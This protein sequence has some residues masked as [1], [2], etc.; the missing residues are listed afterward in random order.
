MNMEAWLIAGARRPSVPLLS[1]QFAQLF[2]IRCHRFDAAAGAL[3]GLSGHPC[4]IA[5]SYETLMELDRPMKR[6]LKGLV[7]RGT[8]LYVRGDFVRHDKCTLAPFVDTAFHYEAERSACAYRITSCRPVPAVFAEECAPGKFVLPSAAGLSEP[9]APIAL[10]KRDDGSSSPF[11]FALPYGRGIAIYDLMPDRPLGDAQAPIL[12]RLADPA[13]RPYEIGALFAARIAAGRDPDRRP[14]LN[15]T[16]DDRPINYDYFTLGHWLKWLE[17]SERLCAGVRID[18][19]WIPNQRHPAARYLEVLRRFNTGFVWH[20]LRRHVDHQQL[21]DLPLEYAEGRRM[22]EALERRHGVKFQ[23]IVVVPFENFDTALLRFLREAGFIA[24]VSHAPDRSESAHKVPSYL[25]D[26]GPLD[27]RYLDCFPVLR[28][29][30]SRELS[31]D[32]MLAQAALDLPI[33]ASVHPDE[34]GLQRWHFMAPSHKT[35]TR[36]DSVLRFAADKQL[37]P[38]SLE[39]IAIETLARPAAAVESATIS[40]CGWR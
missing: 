36:F 12:R 21:H 6:L 27:E 4:L 2:G 25:R 31:R 35:H 29:R 13:A 10:A 5:L 14:A 7:R 17:R 19:A 11:I 40:E 38:Q 16:F 37:R 28:R 15:F 18:F 39:Q 24:T 1:E 34:L 22:V 9:A 8:T 32:L 20:G 26:S 3:S 23:P 33:I 30:N